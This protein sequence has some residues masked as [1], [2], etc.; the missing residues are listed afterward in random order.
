MMGHNRPNFDNIVEESLARGIYLIHLQALQR[1]IK[2]P[3]LDERHRLVLVALTECINA[4]TAMAYPGR[5]WLV[6][7][8]VRYVHGEPRKYSE[9]TIANTLSEL[10]EFGYLYVTR[11]APE[12]GK[13]ALSHYAV[14]SPSVEELQSE[15]ALACAAIR[16]LP[17]RQ[18]PRAEVNSGVDVNSGCDVK[19]VVDIRTGQKIQQPI[20]KPQDDGF[21]VKSGNDVNSGLD[22]N[23]FGADVNSRRGQELVT[24]LVEKKEDKSSY[25]KSD[26][27]SDDDDV[28][29]PQMSRDMQEAVRLYN[30]V[31][32]EA[33]LPTVRVLRLNSHRQ[34]LLRARLKDAGGLKGWAEAISNLHN[35]PFCKGQNNRGWM[36][37]FDFILKPESFS[38]LWSGR[39]TDP[40]LR[41]GPSGDSAASVALR[42]A[43]SKLRGEDDP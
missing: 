8:I 9:G 29:V 36:A 26:S 24:E 3:R 5:A 12:N 42:D 13:R 27:K 43:Y 14:H 4:K 33:G 31:A 39:Y 41:K 16:S 21:E 10:V 17:K 2:D 30:L 37:D 19:N 6:N 11:R 38:K 18:F 35:S 1:C 15:I 28:A 22:V 34:K 7:N 20:E 40:K 25:S 23:F 32:D